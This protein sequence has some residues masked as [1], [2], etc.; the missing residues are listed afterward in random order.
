MLKSKSLYL[1][2]PPLGIGHRNFNDD[3]FFDAERPARHCKICGASYQPELARS[4]DFFH[5]EGVRLVVDQMLKR[6]AVA[7]K[8]KHSPRELLQL[9]NSGRFMTPEAAI[10]L[11]PLGIYPIQDL[12]FD[13]EVIQAGM[14][15]PRAP[16]ND[17]PSK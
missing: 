9:A 17:I 4:P 1:T 3:F 10:K 5:Q 2:A 16:F 12:T 15:S 7:H 6:W 8:D 11:I 13:T 14:E